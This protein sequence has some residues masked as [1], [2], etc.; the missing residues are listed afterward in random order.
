MHAKPLASLFL[1]AGLALAQGAQAVV[2]QGASGSNPSTD[3]SGAGTVAFDLDL[4]TFAPT[5]F[6]F[7]L[8]EADLAGPLAFNALVR[9][10][11]GAALDQFSFSLTGITF[12]ASGS[13]M[14]AF[15][16]IGTVSFGPQAANIAFATPEWAEFQFGNPFGAAA[17]SDW[18]LATTGLRAGDSFTITAA[19]TVAAEVPEPGTAAMMVPALCML[20]LMA[21]RRRKRG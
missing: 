4:A 12:A 8:E 21:A 16:T 11:G 6:R 18:L 10:I 5:T 13:V 1:A 17:G 9:N 3:Y 15:G 14:P 19:N 20:G 7:T 2:L